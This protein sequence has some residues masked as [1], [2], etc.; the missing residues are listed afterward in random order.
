MPEKQ[1]VVS[2]R[3]YRPDTFDMVIG[4]ATVT[5]T[6]RRQIEQQ[7]IAH[8]YLF[9]GPR[10]VGK[11][12]CARIFAKTICCT[13]RTPEGEACNACKSCEQFNS[14]NSRDISEFDAASNNKTDDIRRLIEQVNENTPIFGKYC[15]YII[16][17]VHM[18]TPQAF[19]TFLKTLEEPPSYVVFIFATTEKHKVLPTILSRCQIYDFNRIQVNDTIDALAAIAEKENVEYERDALNLIALKADGAMRDALSI[20]DQVVSFSEAHVTREQVVDGLNLLDLNVYFEITDA[21][22]GKDA[23]K[24]LTILNEVIQKGFSLSNFLSGFTVHFRNLILASNPTG[25]ALLDVGNELGAQYETH[26]KVGA[27]QTFFHCLELC[28]DAEST[29]RYAT[30][31]RL[32]VELLLLTLCEPGEEEKKNA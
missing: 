29:L 7:R 27:V 16:D 24:A 1:F 6:L 4:Q 30:N 2:A 5:N 21:I 17:E 19:N 18:L 23:M 13:N 20:F 8:A 9:C 12:T 32:H 28:M 26:A 14:G 10:G 11:T 3:K 22:L 15:V 31:Q 25:A